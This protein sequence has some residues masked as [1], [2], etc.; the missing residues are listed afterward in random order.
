MDALFI[1]FTIHCRTIKRPCFLAPLGVLFLTLTKNWSFRP[2]AH[3][4][5]L[6][7][8]NSGTMKNTVDMIWFK[9]PVNKISC[10]TFSVAILQCI[11]I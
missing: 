4:L 1:Y 9:N 6:R 10:A 3:I 8:H 11:K 2:F 7:L 5:H